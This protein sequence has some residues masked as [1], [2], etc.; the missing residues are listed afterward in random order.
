M[1]TRD[2]RVRLLGEDAGASRALSKVTKETQSAHD[3]FGKLGSQLSA[4][5][6]PFGVAQ[7]AIDGIAGGFQHV[8]EHGRSVGSILTGIGVA[9]TGAGVLLAQ[10]GAKDQQAQ[11]QL[12]QSISLTGN[13][14]GDFKER[15]EDAIRTGERFGHTADD[16]QDALNSLTIA[17][18]DPNKALSEMGTV[19]DIAAKKHIS[20]RDASDLLIKA[21]SGSTRAFKEFGIV[22]D[23]NGTK[24][25][26][27]DRALQELSKR[28]SGQAS[29]AADTFSGRLD[30]AKTKAEDYLASLAKFAP[31]LTAIGP[32][33]TGVGAAISY[34][35]GKKKEALAVNEDLEASARKE[36]ANSTALAAASA[37]ET[38]ATGA[39]V[40]AKETEVGAT[41]RVIAAEGAE[42]K[43]NQVLA[44]SNEEVAATEAAKGGLGARLIGGGGKFVRA[45]SLALGGYVA[46]SVASSLIGGTAGHVLGGVASGAGVGAGLGSFLGPEGTILGA[47]I[48]AVAG[49]LQSV[50]GGGDNTPSKD[51]LSALIASGPAGKQRVEDQLKKWEDLNKKVGLG[52]D[53]VKRY[54]SALDE[55]GEAE[56]LNAEN[57]K[58]INA[59]AEKQIPLIDKD[60][61]A[62]HHYTDAALASSGAADAFQKGVNDLTAATVKNKQGNDVVVKTL[63]G[64]SDAAIANRDSIR[65][66]AAAELQ[67]LDTLR[68]T[69][70]DTTKLR[71]TAMA[72]STEFEKQAVKVFGN[73]KAVDQL[74]GS[75]HLL[76]RQVATEIKLSHADVVEARLRRIKS[77]I[78]T[79]PTDRVINMEL[80]ATGHGGRGVS[81]GM[82]SGGLV[83]GGVPGR[84]SVPAMLMPGEF[85]VDKDAKNLKVTAK[86]GG[87]GNTY[88]INYSGPMTAE[89]ARELDKVLRK[90]HSDTNG[91]MGYGL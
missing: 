63:T 40:A 26:Q 78:G 7:E 52:G 47:G 46:G 75:L 71:T 9:A 86:G 83:T 34:M 48:G 49:G 73:K 90:L 27:I 77:L 23:G 80:V 1:P 79:I 5:G 68:K 38:A 33:A 19:A 91:Q 42:V 70:S 64:T 16:T 89:G 60:V 8:K 50:L 45:G 17:L 36:L 55:A 43:A 20:L 74:L 21:Q 82:A 18:Q 58:A 41:G 88:N 67:R 29:S 57:L 61:T 25:E 6:G 24:A 37:D 4:L 81:L 62:L 76:P 35:A 87:G 72:M 65:Q 28:L 30:A 53:V 51:Q 39:L 56:K 32:V 44:T 31:I 15:I 2:L 22:L 3:A 69:T 10:F 14:Y 13:S 11:A 59:Q 66:L 54:K 84:D 12:R 85:V